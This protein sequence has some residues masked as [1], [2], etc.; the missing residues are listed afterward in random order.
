MSK[1]K[2]LKIKIDF[3]CIYKLMQINMITT[4]P[5]MRFYIHDFEFRKILNPS[6][7]EAWITINYRL[8]KENC[9]IIKLFR[10]NNDIATRTIAKQNN[11]YLHF[12]D[13]RGRIKIVSNNHNDETY[14]F[15]KAINA[16]IERITDDMDYL[17]RKNKLPIVGDGVQ[18]HQRPPSIITGRPPAPP[19]PVPPAPAPPAPAPPAPAPPPPAPPPLAPPPLAPPPPA[20]PSSAPPQ[21]ALLPP[22]S[23][24]NG[25]IVIITRPTPEILSKLFTNNIGYSLAPEFLF[26]QMLQPPPIYE[27]AEIH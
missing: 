17:K 11:V 21:P 9:N 8:L 3:I 15:Q 13:T 14:H 25:L 26:N 6:S 12:E 27:D 1:L 16:V 23:P 5:F 10:D 22:A 24:L 19:P 20:I 18:F 4:L 2:A 7:R